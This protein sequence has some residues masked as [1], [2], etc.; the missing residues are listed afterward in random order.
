[1]Y[2]DCLPYPFYVQFWADSTYNVLFKNNLSI[3]VLLK[4]SVTGY[5]RCC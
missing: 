5:N 3:T 2:L 1:M 4:L